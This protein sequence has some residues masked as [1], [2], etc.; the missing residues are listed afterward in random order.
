MNEMWITLLPFALFFI[1]LFFF[2]MG[3][4]KACPDC[5]K[6]FSHIQSPFTKTRR[7]W[8]EGGYLCQNCGCETDLAGRKVPAGTSPQRR[9]IIL[10]AGLLTLALVP[11]IVFITM[12]F[13]R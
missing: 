4:R 7:Q 6:P 3:S 13:Q 2:G 12:L 8:F 11:A 10:G 1:W 9:S 5:N